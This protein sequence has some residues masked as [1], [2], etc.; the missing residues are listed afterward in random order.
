MYNTSISQNNHII[1]K[2]VKHMRK[3]TRNDF[4]SL[5]SKPDGGII[6]CDKCG[7]ITGFIY[8]RTHKYINYMFMCKCSNVGRAEIYRGRRPTLEY[9]MRKL[10]Q[11]ENL[12]ICPNCERIIFRVM[13][14]AVQNY[15]FNVICKCGVEYDLKYYIKRLEEK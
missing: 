4:N 15:A 2:K 11:K 6:N 3:I 5:I 1:K 14:D 7:R 8:E 10:Y 9:P 13:D 12:H